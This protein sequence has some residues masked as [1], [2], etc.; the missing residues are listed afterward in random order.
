MVSVSKLLEILNKPNLLYWSN[1]LGL[2]GKSL[3]EYYE[4]VKKDGT[5]KHN[6]IEL[7]LKNGIKFKGYEVL[8]KNLLNYDVISI[9]ETFDNGYIL[10]R[11]DLI[12]KNK[13]TNELI[14][15]D[16]KRNKSI[17]LGTKL[18]LSCYKHLSNCDKIAYINSENF[19][20]KELNIN[21]EKYYEIIKRLY[22]IHILLNNLNE[23]L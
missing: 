3:K 13:T 7:Y 1:N 9:E 20:I 17:Y 10:G 16:F 2:K 21:T 6:E 5:N 8:E 19:E 18:Q 12:L 23:K 14:V 4:E 15:C 22:Q 11:V